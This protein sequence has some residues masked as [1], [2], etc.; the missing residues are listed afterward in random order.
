MEPSHK[1]PNGLPLTGK[2]SE[3]DVI[4]VEAMDGVSAERDQPTTSSFSAA[5][6]RDFEAGSM[7]MRERSIFDSFP[8][9]NRYILLGL[10]SFAAFLVPFSGECCLLLLT[11]CC[12]C[13]HSHA[14]ALRKPCMHAWTMSIL[15]MRIWSLQHGLY[16]LGCA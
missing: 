6:F 9:R 14:R 4:T 13:P 12:K 16:I 15:H 5:D 2:L 1:Q 8:T 3:E 7:V 11:A 10:M